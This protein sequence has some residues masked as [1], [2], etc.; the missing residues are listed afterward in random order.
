[1]IY[2]YKLLKFL[3]FFLNNIKIFLK[4]SNILSFFL[5]FILLPKEYISYL[6]NQ[7]ALNSEIL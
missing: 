3:F 4:Q 7:Q 6:C 1:M 2:I 5:F